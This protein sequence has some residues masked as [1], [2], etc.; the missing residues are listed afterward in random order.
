MRPCSELGVDI[1]KPRE[2]NRLRKTLTPPTPLDSSGSKP[3]T[4]ETRA[5]DGLDP[6]A[7]AQEL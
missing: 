5:H 1:D 3:A 2:K 7:G 6:G 4:F